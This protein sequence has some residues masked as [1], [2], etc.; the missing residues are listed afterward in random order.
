MVESTLGDI[1]HLLK[2]GKTPPSKIAEYFEEGYNWYTPSD[3][4][5]SKTLSFSERNV[6]ELAV[7][8]KKAI[9]YPENSL[10]ITCIGDIGRV[11][12]SNKL[13]SSNQQITAIKPKPEINIDYLYYWFIKNKRLLSDTSNNAVV[14]I[15]N[16]YS[17]KK[18]K[19]NY[20]PL[21]TQ[22]RIAQILDNAAA[23]RDKTQQLLTE[24]DQLAQS[25]FL[26]M[27]GDPGI[28]LKEWKIENFGKHIDVL[29][30]YH[31]N[32]SYKILSKN[33]ELTTNPDYALMV[34][35][36]DLENNN[37]E[38]GVNYISEKAYHFL[39][40][41]KVFGGEIIINKIGSAGKVYFM[42]HLNRPVS[43]GMNAFMIRLRPSM[44]N[45]FAF[46]HL[47][48][49]YGEWQINKRVKGAVTKTIRKD[50]VREIPFIV[51]PIKLQN[52][53]AEKIAL[54]EQQKVLAKQELQQSE[55]LFNCLLQKAFKGELV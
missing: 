23:L 54:I 50:A 22:K 30:D 39:S 10:L 5:K 14:P 26:E 6:S 40:K 33:V 3:I 55:D 51:P 2:T 17:L 19:F 9:I 29:T 16:N 46:F 32:G 44:N 27:F 38:E 7:Q 11:G 20:P 36:T 37:F 47:Q 43:L 18:I 52:Q 53:F 28:N 49:K 1:S 45:I 41:S 21:T 13:C 8:D 15:L 34:R 24:Y 25:I 31:A 4:G 12:I 35:T 48:T 42:P